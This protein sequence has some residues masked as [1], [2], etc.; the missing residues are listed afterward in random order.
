MIYTDFTVRKD[1]FVGHMVEPERNNTNHAVI[2][3]MGGE[4]SI[5]SGI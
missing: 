5:V 3:I 1:G 4:K 2:V